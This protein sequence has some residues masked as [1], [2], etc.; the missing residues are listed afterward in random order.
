MHLTVADDVYE[1]ATFYRGRG[2]SHPR[3][4]SIV[5]GPDT[6]CHQPPHERPTIEPN[7]DDWSVELPVV[8]W[9]LDAVCRGDL[10]AENVR[11]YLIECSS[12]PGGCCWSCEAIRDTEE[13]VVA[14]CARARDE[15]FATWNA[16]TPESHPYAATGS[17]LHAWDCRT[18]P[19]PVP[20][21]IIT[22]KHAYVRYRY[23][24]EHGDG[25]RDPYRR[26]TIDEA[27]R[28]TA[29]RCKICAPALPGAWRDETSD[30]RSTY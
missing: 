24:Y 25:R 29:R 16:P 9:L 4:Y 6:G 8:L 19:E 17:S 27:K 26:L 18:L 28:W 30:V 7:R 22:S 1:F 5:G 14:Q 10:T 23:D 21:P 15:W 11:G 13:V 3:A 20:P 2:H 12:P